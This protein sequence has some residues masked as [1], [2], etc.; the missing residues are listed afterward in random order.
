[1]IRGHVQEVEKIALLPKYPI[2]EE[3]P[4]SKINRGRDSEAQRDSKNRALPPQVEVSGE[5]KKKYNQSTL[6][7]TH[8][9]TQDPRCGN[10]PEGRRICIGCDDRCCKY[11]KDADAAD[12]NFPQSGKRRVATQEVSE[13]FA[14]DNGLYEDLS[15]EEGQIAPP[16]DIIRED[17]RVYVYDVEDA[18]PRGLKN[19]VTK[20]GRELLVQPPSPHQESK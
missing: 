14:N 19:C 17:G 4:T 18:S 7:H 6:D 15:D 16:I 8:A 11:K 13:N 20:E 1:M 10:D 12:K 9:S 3:G 2:C 5:D